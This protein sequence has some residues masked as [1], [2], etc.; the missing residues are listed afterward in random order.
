MAVF[1][2]HGE[3]QYNGG[4]DIKPSP[5]P[6]KSDRTPALFDM[7]NISEA[8]MAKIEQ[9]VKAAKDTLALA[10][11]LQTMRDVNKTLWKIQDSLKGG[12]TLGRRGQSYI[13]MN[14]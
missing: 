1:A 7:N 5:L 12:L 4:M 9:S 14:L 8:G 10:D 6:L 3:I 2:K 11:R 13:S